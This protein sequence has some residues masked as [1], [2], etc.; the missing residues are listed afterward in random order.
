MRVNAPMSSSSSFN[1]ADELMRPA[2]EHG[3][4]DRAAM[5]TDG[6]TITYGALAAMINRAGN[7]MASAG[8][9]RGERVMMLLPD[10]PEL[11]ASYLGAIKIG[12]VAIAFNTRSSPAELAFALEDSAAKLLIIDHTLIETYRAAAS[13]R[14]AIKPR[15]FVVGGSCDGH[16]DYDSLVGSASVDLRAE[17]MS[18]SD[19][20]CWIYT[21]GT[22]GSPKAAVHLHRDVAAAGPYLAR[23]LGVRDGDRMFSTSKLFFAYALGNCLFG[24]LRMCCTVVL[25]SPWPEAGAIADVIESTRPDFVFSVPTMLRNLLASG[26]A[27]ESGFRGARAFVS[28]GE[29]MPATLAA[30]WRDVSGVPIIEGMG[31]S[32]TIY[33]IFSNSVGGYRDGSAGRVAPDAE[34][35][36]VDER[37]DTITEP[38][39]PGALWVR[40]PSVCAGY[41]NR[42]EL[43]RRQ[44]SGSWFRT[45]DLFAFDPDGFYFHHGRSD[46]ML[47]IAGLWVSPAEIE[48][49]V[50]TITG[51]AD[52]AVVGVGDADGLTRPTLFVVARDP[53]SDRGEMID[54]IRHALDRDLAAHKRPRDIRFVENLLRTATGKLKR[55]LIA[56]SIATPAPDLRDSGEK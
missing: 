11:V 45:G 27:D 35:R 46:E 49:C 50:M 41:W 10:T 21:S 40:M 22:T 30:R 18:P 4:D 32:E 9:A 16:E 24:A 1:A 17:S 25:H 42:E 19:M 29:R 37:G 48:E 36:L 55:Y 53:G 14:L 33:M 20:A 23:C 7:A 39:M 2:A 43:S 5:I 38:G 47:K 34:V 31:T 15:V 3:L 26:R 28:A 44:F 13:A 54:R 6:R 52:A 8:I 51:I 12:A 56:E